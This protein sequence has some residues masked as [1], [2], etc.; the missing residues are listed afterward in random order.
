MVTVNV[1]GKSAEVAKGSSLA[2]LAKLHKRDRAFVAKVDGEL[3]DL[4]AKLERDC[5]VEFLDFESRQ[6]REAFWHSGAHLLAQAVLRHFPKAL[7]TIGPPVEEGFYYD[8]DHEPFSKEDL[9]KIEQEVEHIVKQKLPSERIE[10]TKV[11]ALEMFGKNPYKAELIEEFGSGLSAYKQGEF[12]DLC[13]GPHVPHTGWFRGVKVLNVAGAYW[14][15]DQANKQLQRIYAIAFPE[16]EQLKQWLF[17]REEAERRDHK[18]LGKLLDL[19]SV[20]EKIGPGMPLFHPKG[21]LVRWE[22]MQFIRGQNA[23]LG[24]LEVATPHVARALLW[25]SSGHYEAFKEKMYIFGIEGEEYA[26]KPMNCPFHSHIYKSEPRSYRDLPIAYAEFGT[27]YRHEKS[28]ELT[29]LLRVR[30]LTQDDGHMYVRPDQITEQ[31]VRIVTVALETLRVFGIEQFQ[32]NLSTRP[33]NAIGDIAVWDRAESALKEALSSAGITFVL[34][35]KEGAFY[36]PKVDIDIRDALGRAWQCSTIQL[37]FFMPE[38]FD[39]VYMDES[40]QYRRPVMIHRALLGTLDRFL[41]ILIEH[42]AGKF[43]VWLAPVQVRIMTIADRFDA[44]ARELMAYLKEAGLRVEL[45]DSQ[46]SVNRKVR[47]A[48]LLKIPLLLTV[49][50][51]EMEQRT[52]AVRTLDGKVRF[53]M[54]WEEFRGLVAKAVSERSQVVF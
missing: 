33:D 12:V 48:Q 43:P 53:G 15:G 8:I 32:V 50:E 41:A 18:K 20:H 17:V 11:K 52:V 49:G 16:K 7:L 38:R 24:F 44:Y 22:M 9:Q 40:G 14:H 46:G 42:Y 2:E 51:K 27:V 35:E 6:G 39:L 29:G 28:G 54:G 21:A 36:G 5:T 25:K 47:D 26:L 37:D 31:V 13:R 45:D 1:D 19:F 10:L 30:S 23:K 4:S 34:K 3:K